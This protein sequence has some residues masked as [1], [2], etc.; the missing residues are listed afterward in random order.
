MRRGD[1]RGT[2]APSTIAARWSPSPVTTG[3]NKS[4]ENDE[5]RKKA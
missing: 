2:A 3:R 5:D 1:L 4:A